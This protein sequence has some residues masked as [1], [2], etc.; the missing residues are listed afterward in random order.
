MI[1]GSLYKQDQDRELALGIF[2][3]LRQQTLANVTDRAEYRPHSQRGGLLNRDSLF[4]KEYPLLYPLCNPA[5]D[6]RL[7]WQGAVA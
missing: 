3:G 1:G 2:D 7:V 4:I 6:L 5:G